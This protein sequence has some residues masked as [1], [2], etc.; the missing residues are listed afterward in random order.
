MPK[1]PPANHESSNQKQRGDPI[2]IYQAE[3][4]VNHDL[5]SSAQNES[6]GSKKTLAGGLGNAALCCLLVR[7]NVLLP[8]VRTSS[9]APFRSKCMDHEEQPGCWR[10]Q[11]TDPSTD[12]MD[13]QQRCCCWEAS[14]KGL[15]LEGAGTSGLQPGCPWQQSHCARCRSAPAPCRSAGRHYCKRM[16]GSSAAAAC[17]AACQHGQASGAWQEQCDIAD[18]DTEPWLML[19]QTGAA[20]VAAGR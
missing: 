15:G 18:S 14:L 16:P 3:R 12:Y 8:H 7:N 11:P 13:T 9:L 2:T 10:Q 5:S 6:R 17:T 19:V 1:P 4:R 20:S